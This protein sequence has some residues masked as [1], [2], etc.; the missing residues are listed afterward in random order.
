MTCDNGDVWF[1]TNFNFFFC[2]KFE[3]CVIFDVNIFLDENEKII[4]KGKNFQ[5]FLTIQ[6]RLNTWQKGAVFQAV[7]FWHEFQHKDKSKHKF[8]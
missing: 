7:L 8:H 6:M 5:S 4:P 2:C 1:F 3:I